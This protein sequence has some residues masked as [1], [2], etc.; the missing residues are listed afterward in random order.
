[1]KSRLLILSDLWGFRNA[2]WLSN[3]TNS[4]KNEYEIVLLDC[5]EL[6]DIEMEPYEQEYLHQQYR[7]GGIKRAVAKLCEAE[8]GPV[9]VL[10]FSIGATIAWKAA[11]NG[12]D[13]HK[14]VGVSGTRLRMEIRKPDCDID[15]LFGERD[16]FR[17]HKDWFKDMG[18]ENVLVPNGGHRIYTDPS[19]AMEI[20]EKFAQQLAA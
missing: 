17:P 5:C 15:L 3:Y 12:L 20:C 14:F 13:V 6:G 7:Q 8:N 4:L 16:N 18:L 9:D 19:V 2:D 10:A 11:M 1:M